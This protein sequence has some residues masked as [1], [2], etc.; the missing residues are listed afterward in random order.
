LKKKKKKFGVLGQNQNLAHFLFF[1][2]KIL[3]FALGAKTKHLISEPLR[4]KPDA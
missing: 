1:F 2:Q 4:A 3:M